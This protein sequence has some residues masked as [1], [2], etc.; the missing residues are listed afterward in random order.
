MDH[1]SAVQHIWSQTLRQGISRFLSDFELTFRHYDFRYH[2]RFQL[3]ALPIDIHLR[4]PDI[5]PHMIRKTILVTNPIRPKRI[6]RQLLDTI[7]SISFDLRSISII[8]KRSGVNPSLSR[9]QSRAKGGHN[10][11]RIWDQRK[12]I[13]CP[14]RCQTRYTPHPGVFPVLGIAHGEFTQPPKPSQRFDATAGLRFYHQDDF[15]PCET[16]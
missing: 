14:Q 4:N 16:M 15:I 9:R 3:I 6:I 7:W 1:P 10:N 11:Y 13:V 12:D 2:L 5:F 8:R